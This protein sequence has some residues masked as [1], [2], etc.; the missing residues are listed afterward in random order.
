MTAPVQAEALR[1]LEVSVSPL[2][3]LSSTLRPHWT[4]ERTLLL[5]GQK[6][7]RCEAK[8]AATTVTSQTHGARNLL[9]RGELSQENLLS[10]PGERDTCNQP[11]GVFLHPVHGNPLSTTPTPGPVLAGRT[12]SSL[13]CSLPY[14]GGKRQADPGWPCIAERRGLRSE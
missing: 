4:K 13:P 11:S 8:P 14:G 10:T 9:R 12:G 2:A 6:M 3:L 7:T 5:S 1:C